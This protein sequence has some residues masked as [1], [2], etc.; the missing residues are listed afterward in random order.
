MINC[1]F[2]F[3][4]LIFWKR[5]YPF[6]IASAVTLY[7]SNFSFVKTLKTIGKNF[8]WGQTMFDSLNILAN[9]YFP[10]DSFILVLW[11]LHPNL[12][13]FFISAK[14]VSG[15]FQYFSWNPVISGRAL[16]QFFHF[17]VFLMAKSIFDMRGGA[18]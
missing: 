3:V 15:K 14:L 4:F 5:L 8:K 9:E 2:M 6:H 18:R 17:P 12:N 1:L 11:L 16:L 7:F 13:T 10:N